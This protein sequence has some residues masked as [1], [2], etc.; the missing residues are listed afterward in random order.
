MIVTLYDGFRVSAR[1]N[2]LWGSVAIYNKYYSKGNKNVSACITPS[3]AREYFAF[4][5]N[6]R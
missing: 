5:I 2:G 3:T 4:G 1:P 6:S